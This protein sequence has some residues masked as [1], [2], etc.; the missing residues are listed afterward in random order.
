M[1]EQ[2]AK[3]AGS[4][5]DEY[6]KRN[7]NTYTSVMARVDI[8]KDIRYY[9]P[10]Y[11]DSMMYYHPYTATYKPMTILEVGAGTGANLL[12]IKHL[13]SIHTLIAVEPNW[14]ATQAIREQH[15][16]NDIY[17]M[18]WMDYVPLVKP[19]DLVFTYGVLIHVPPSDRKAFMQKIVYAEDHRHDEQIRCLL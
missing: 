12:A 10:V 2:T 17:N 14:E 11:R 5:G 8:W 7:A 19:I 3:W 13:S 15:I 9:I 6:H 4:F 16:T 18:E 1:N